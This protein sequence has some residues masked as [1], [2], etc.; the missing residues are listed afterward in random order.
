MKITL[1]QSELKLAIADW[2]NKTA[3]TLMRDQVAQVADI[4]IETYPQKA[5]VSVAFV[6]APPPASEKAV[7]EA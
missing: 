6:I 3:P 5:T 7:E 2:L 4:T 1:D